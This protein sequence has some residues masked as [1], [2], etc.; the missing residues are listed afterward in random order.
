MLKTGLY[1][2]II[3][4]FMTGCGEKPRKVV[5]TVP[6]KK[7]K[8]VVK[9]EKFNSFLFVGII[10]HKPGIYKYDVVKKKRTEFW[11]N[12]NEQV[13]ELS[14]SPDRKSAFFLTA[15]YLGK[16]SFL[17][18]ITRVKLYLINLDSSKAKFIK[19]FGDGVQVFTQWDGNSNFKIIFNRSD[20]IIPTY[21]DQQTYIYNVFGKELLNEVQTYDLT[22]SPYP[23]PPHNP[24]DYV[25]PDGEFK[26]VNSTRDSTNLYLENLNEETYSFIASSS[27]KLNNFTWSQDGNYLIASTID[28]AVDNKTLNSKEPATS[29]LYIYDVNQRKVVKE[30]KGAGVKNFFIKNDFLIFDDGF[31]E[32]SSITIINYRTLKVSAIIK[33]RSGCGLRSIPELPDIKA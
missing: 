33:L 16:K 15:G 4:L 26:I 18:Y 5:K 8:P 21:I 1:L 25:S 20:K 24:L 12:Y 2:L 9:N 22:K 30:W 10:I 28:I 23:R 3:L 13:V 14:Y 7:E 31:G 19:D 6:V 29:N 11:S 17:P 32:K 27:Q